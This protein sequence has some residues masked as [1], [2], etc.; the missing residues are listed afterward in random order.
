MRH[1]R[2]Y[3]AATPPLKLAVYSAR[4]SQADGIQSMRSWIDHHDAATRRPEDEPLVDQLLFPHYKPAAR[5]YIDD[6]AIRFE[7]KFPS[8]DEL[9]Y[10]FRVWNEADK[11]GSRRILQV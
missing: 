10:A 9:I 8:L 3:L 1:L 11:I 7:G 5:V 4:S 6:R 2:G